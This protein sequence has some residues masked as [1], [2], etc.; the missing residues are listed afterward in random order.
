VAAVISGLLVSLEQHI[1]YVRPDLFQAWYLLDNLLGLA[2]GVTFIL[3]MQLFCDQFNLHESRRRWGVMMWLYV[4][5]IVAPVA[6]FQLVF[7][8]ALLAH[9]SFHVGGAAGLFVM[10]LVFA[11]MLIPVVYGLLSIKLM[12]AEI[13]SDIA[14]S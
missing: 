8:V 7:L 3:A 11:V 2:G 9:E 13:K 1:I 4:A 10:I 14:V 5:M 12:R 6:L